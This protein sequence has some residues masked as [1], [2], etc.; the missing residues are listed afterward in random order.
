M[1][2]RLT[3]HELKEQARFDDDACFTLRAPPAG[4]ER[5]DVIP[6]GRYRLGRGEVNVA[7]EEVD[8][9]LGHPLARHLVKAALG[10]KLP[11]RHLIFRYDPRTAGKLSLVEQVVGRS[12]WMCLGQVTTKAVTGQKHPVLVAVTDDGV[13][14]EHEVCAAL[15]QVPA[16]ERDVASVP[17]QRVE[18]LSELLAAVKDQEV[19]DLQARFLEDVEVEIRKYQKTAKD[20]DDFLYGKRW[21]SIRR[22]RR[23]MRRGG[24]PRNQATWRA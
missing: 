2:L 13:A 10:R 17:L 1:L 23:K 3:R 21:S 18:A 14:L 5:A 4:A 19:A 16:A 22:S 15:F 6:G 7:G 12:G 8:Y 9:R 24:P 11:V 20:L